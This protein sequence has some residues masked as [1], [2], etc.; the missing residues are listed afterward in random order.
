MFKHKTSL[1]KLKSSSSHQKSTCAA[2]S[3]LLN[4]FKMS[5]QR[6]I[7]SQ[8]YDTLGLDDD[9][10]EELKDLLNQSKDNKEDLKNLFRPEPNISLFYSAVKSNAALATYIIHF[11]MEHEVDSNVLLDPVDG[12]HPLPIA[13]SRG[14]YYL[15]EMMLQCDPDVPVDHLFQTDAQGRTLLHL[16]AIQGDVLSL[17]TILRFASLKPSTA[18]NLLQPDCQKR[19]PIHYLAMKYKTCDKIVDVLTLAASK[20]V[21]LMPLL[22]ADSEGRTPLH[23]I[24]NHKDDYIYDFIP[25]K[26]PA[27]A[28]RMLQI[29]DGCSHLAVIL[30]AD[31]QGQTPFHIAVEKR[32]KGIIEE[33]ISA[34]ECDKQL[35]RTLFARDKIGLTPLSRAFDCRNKVA[36]TVMLFALDNGINCKTSVGRKYSDLVDN[37]DNLIY[38]QILRHPWIWPT[39]YPSQ[40]R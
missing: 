17:E 10:I 36:E 25:R 13:F 21:E 30:K 35:A 1:L 28:K 2:V 32:H 14:E 33:I 16:L 6:K 15:V 7:T 29:A 12:I 38:R 22:L 3:A 40:S 26:G 24:C 37:M 19:T 18:T 4:S 11:A 5:A 39:L 20:R 31:E 23:M 34:T 27:A 9:L 8:H